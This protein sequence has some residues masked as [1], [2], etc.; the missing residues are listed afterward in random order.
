MAPICKFSKTVIRG[1]MRRPSGAWA[2]PIR[3]IWKVSRLVMSRPSKWICPDAARGLP[4][5]VISRVDLP[6]PLAPIKVTI[7]PLATL[8]ST[9]R[10]AWML[11]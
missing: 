1:K 4:Q 11:P 3:M 7:S 10:S 5:T 8:R 9:P 6:A 2:T